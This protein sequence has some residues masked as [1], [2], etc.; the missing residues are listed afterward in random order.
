[1]CT[2]NYFYN[3]IL[4]TYVPST[5]GSIYNAVYAVILVCIYVHEGC[6]HTFCILC[7]S[8]KLIEYYYFLFI[9][10]YLLFI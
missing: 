8:S 9:S 1:M 5:C 6:I 10:F 3:K 2:F 7:L 4:T